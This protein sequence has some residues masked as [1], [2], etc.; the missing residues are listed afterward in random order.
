MPNV[1]GIWPETIYR[2]SAYGYPVK[3]TEVFDDGSF[4]GKPMY[5]IMNTSEKIHAI[6]D[7]KKLP[8]AD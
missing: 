1:K 7:T 8:W 4:T 5:S 3:P 6:A 2:P